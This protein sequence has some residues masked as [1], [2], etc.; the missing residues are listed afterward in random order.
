MLKEVGMH[1]CDLLNNANFSQSVK[2]HEEKLNICPSD[3]TTQSNF[4]VLRKCKKLLF[5]ERILFC[6]LP[7]LDIFRKLDYIKDT[8]R[9]LSFLP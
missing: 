1:K 2:T 4:L 7:L 6:V 8:K 5:L 3:V 9:R